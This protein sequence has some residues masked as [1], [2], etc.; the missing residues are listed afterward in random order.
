MRASQVAGSTGG[1]AGPGGITGGGSSSGSGL[2]G[3]PNQYSAVWDINTS[4][5]D[6]ATGATTTVREGVRVLINQ[7]Q[8]DAFC[9]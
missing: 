6:A 2:N 8:Y 5:A 3:V 1:A 9:H 4:V 7:A